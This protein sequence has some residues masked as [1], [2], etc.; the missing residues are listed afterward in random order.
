MLGARAAKTLP[1]SGELQLCNLAGLPELCEHGLTLLRRSS[2]KMG[3]PSHQLLEKETELLEIY[4]V[5]KNNDGICVL[6]LYFIIYF[7]A[8]VCFTKLGL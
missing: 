8:P 3:G 7:F 1:G 2:F 5:E 4:I 6:F